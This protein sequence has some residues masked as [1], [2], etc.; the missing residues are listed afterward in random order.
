MKK[1]LILSIVISLLGCTAFK[2]TSISKEN[3]LT[4]LGRYDTSVVIKEHWF[5][6][7]TTIVYMQDTS[8]VVIWGKECAFRKNEMLYA[9]AEWWSTPPGMGH[10]KYVLMNEDDNI[11]YRLLDRQ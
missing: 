1:L 8:C 11:H 4:E 10:W 7:S 2:H 3:C 6:G 9:K 5:K